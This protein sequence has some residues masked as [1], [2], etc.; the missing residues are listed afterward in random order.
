MTDELLLYGDLTYK[1][2]GAAL[3]VHKTLGAGFLEGVYETA[4]AYELNQLGLAFERQKALPVLY[5]G[6]I[7]GEYKADFVIEDKVIAELKA[8]KALSPVDEAQLINYLK[9]TG[10]EVGLLLNFGVQSLQHQRRV[11]SHKA[12]SAKSA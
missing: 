10:L 7:A 5:K 1:I 2:I 9:A 12:S 4:M 6:G 11:L 3:E 8:Q